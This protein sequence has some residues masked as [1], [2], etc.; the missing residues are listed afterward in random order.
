MA[1][2]ISNCV[3]CSYFLILLFRLKGETDVSLNPANVSFSKEILSDIFVV[4]VP[5]VF[6][7][8]LNVLSMMTLNNIVAGYGPNAVAS[9]G[10]ASKINQ[11]PIQIIFGFTQGVM[12]LIG[13]NYA[14]KNYSRMKEGIRK[15][16]T[17][18]LGALLVIT[19]L[20][21]TAGQP[22][23]RFFM[24]NDEIVVIGA[25]FLSGFGISLPFMCFDFLVVGISQSFGIGKHAL[26]FSFLRKLAFEIPLIFALNHTVGLYGVAYAQCSAEICMALIATFVFMGLMKKTSEKN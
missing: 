18:T 6:Q 13:Y 8:I 2:F 12:P 25:K 23:I 17:V 19:V 11:L 9:I 22:I 20:F 3:A 15:T 16:A 26:V 4:G 21:N 10:I 1:T 7:N 5:G 24:D 14:A